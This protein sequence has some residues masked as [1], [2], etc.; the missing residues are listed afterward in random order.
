LYLW[1]IHKSF[2]TKLAPKYFVMAHSKTRFAMSQN[3][4]ISQV[5]VIHVQESF[6]IPQCDF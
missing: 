5:F 4:K 6:F 1:L 3:Y 2:P